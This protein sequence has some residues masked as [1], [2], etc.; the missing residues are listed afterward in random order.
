MV[1]FKCADAACKYVSDKPG[2]CCGQE[3]I[4][5]SDEEAEKL[6]AKE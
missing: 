3:L 6:Q 1:K 4:E 2:E 5:I